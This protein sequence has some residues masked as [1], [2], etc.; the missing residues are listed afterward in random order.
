M[1]T[2]GLA[3]MQSGAGIEKWGGIGGADGVE[4]LGPT[5]GEK[6][7]AQRH[8]VRGPS[9][10]RSTVTIERP[11]CA[12]LH[13]LRNHAHQP[14]EQPR[15]QR[16]LRLRRRKTVTTL[17]RRQTKRLRIANRRRLPTGPSNQR[18]LPDDAAGEQTESR[19]TR[20]DRHGKNDCLGRN[21]PVKR[22]PMIDLERAGKQRMRR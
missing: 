6:A 1:K 12:D 11:R 3:L 16:R 21:H 9:S 2:S 10:P 4:P 15:P 17:R 20:H 13:R 18:C 5:K 8:V 7:I 14:T 22:I 19:I